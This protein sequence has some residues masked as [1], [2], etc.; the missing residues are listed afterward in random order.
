MPGADVRIS[1]LAA[2]RRDEGIYRQ[3][4]DD[5]VCRV[6]NPSAIDALETE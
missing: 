1:W 3:V 5:G 2:E 6:S 4:K